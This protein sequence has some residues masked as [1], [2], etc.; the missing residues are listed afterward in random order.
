MNPAHDVHRT[1]RCCD[2]QRAAYQPRCML[3]KAASS[4][5]PA[6][7]FLLTILLTVIVIAVFRLGGLLVRR[8]N[9]HRRSMADGAD[10]AT[11]IHRTH[12]HDLLSDTHT[13]CMQLGRR[14]LGCTYRM[15]APVHMPCLMLHAVY[16]ISRSRSC[17]C[18]LF[19][20]LLGDFDCRHLCADGCCSCGGT[21]RFTHLTLHG[22]G[23]VLKRTRTAN[24]REHE[25]PT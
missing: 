2:E 10:E 9:L 22:C 6:H 17:A 25:H 15:A 16:P 11:G 19:L 20:L 3:C 1:T 24:R 23:H 12:T 21:W 14:A 18:Y 7:L 8:F 5:S 4:R 13:P